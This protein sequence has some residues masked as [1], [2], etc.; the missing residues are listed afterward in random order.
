MNSQEV[1]A[2]L[3]QIRRIDIR[4]ADIIRERDELVKAQTY[5]KSPQTEGDRVQTSPSGDPPWMAY[6]LKWEELINKMGE[7]WDELV[8]KKQEILGQ[9]HRLEDSRYIDI[10]IKRYVMFKSFEQIAVDMNYSY[11]HTLRLHGRALKQM[12]KM[13]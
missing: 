8:E 7:V 11:E 5:M 10:L 3:R 4:L 2:Y 6:L 1:K 9:I 12:G 13:L